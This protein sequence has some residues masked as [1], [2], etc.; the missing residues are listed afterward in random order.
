MV[1]LQAEGLLTYVIHPPDTRS[2]SYDENGELVATYE[3][4]TKNF[5]NVRSSIITKQQDT[6]VVV[7]AW[8]LL[9]L[10]PLLLINSLRATR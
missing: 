4:D 6:L 3:L 7:A 8:L 1:L 9:L 2:E 5:L 10:L